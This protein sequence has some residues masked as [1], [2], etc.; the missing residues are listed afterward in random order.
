MTMHQPHPGQ[1]PIP[2]A[3]TSDAKA[4]EIARIWGASGGQHVTLAS[5][6]WNDPAAWG[7]M[8]AD[9]AR[10][11]ANAYQQSRDMEPSQVLACVKEG[12]DAQWGWPTDQ[13]KGTLLR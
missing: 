7:I 11:V 8:L 13:P 4:R 3:A 10:H 9:L 6:L 5:E 2:P 1:L 12:L